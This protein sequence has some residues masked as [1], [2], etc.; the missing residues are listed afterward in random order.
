M[1][2]RGVG[3]SGQQDVLCVFSLLFLW[4][5][6]Y[7]EHAQV[8]TVLQKGAVKTLSDDGQ[9]PSNAN[10]RLSERRDLHLLL[11]FCQTCIWCKL[12]LFLA[13]ILLRDFINGFLYSF[14]FNPVTG[15]LLVLALG[16]IFR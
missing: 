10:S 6:I 12:V 1:Q 15:Q 2:M 3:I 9:V 7:T 14:C 13:L 5:R 4:H 8:L 16:V 11:Q